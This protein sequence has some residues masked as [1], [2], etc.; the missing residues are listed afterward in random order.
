[1]E[2][3]FSL[4]QG[5]FNDLAMNIVKVLGMPFIVALF[6]G[7]LLERVKVPRKIVTFISIMIFL[8]GSYQM[9]IRID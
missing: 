6:I 4:L 2:I 7:L 3:D 8:L 9:I 5:T 1:M